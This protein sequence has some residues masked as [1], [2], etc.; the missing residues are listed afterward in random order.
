MKTLLRFEYRKWLY[1]GRVWIT[2]LTWCILSALATR[3][4][5]SAIRAINNFNDTSRQYQD[6]RIVNY[7]AQLDSA[8]KG[9][10]AFPKYDSDPRNPVVF[11]RV[12]PRFAFFQ[13]GP[14]NSFATGQSDVF[15][16]QYV[17][18]YRTDYN[19][20]KEHASNGLAVLYGRFDISFLVTF[21]LP[22]FIIALNYN[23]LSAEKENGTLKIL[24]SQGATHLQLACSKTIVSTSFFTLL[25]LVPV[26][27][28]MIMTK[29][30]SGSLN[31]IAAYLAIGFL[32]TLF[33]HILSVFV[34]RMLKSSAYN[35]TLLLSWWLALVIVLPSLVNTLTEIVHPVPSRTKFITEYRRVQS[36][37][38]RDSNSAVLDKYFF[39][40]P[41]LVKQDTAGNQRNKAN[42]FYKASHVTQDKTQKAL[43]PVYAKHDEALRSA[44]AFA[45]R[46]GRISPAVCMQQSLTLLAGQSSMQYQHFNEKIIQWRKQY[47]P[48]ILQKLLQDKEVTTS[49]VERFRPFAYESYDYSQKL[50]INGIVLLL[51]N[52]I[53]AL[54]ITATLNRKQIA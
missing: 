40:H 50:L 33:W 51:I 9:F 32:Y 20:Q 10:K 21:L 18:S 49:E 26:V 14:L 3:Q 6:I 5:V 48:F 34:N 45:T 37:I 1:S 53:L 29:D 31:A 41:E 2:L 24:H 11:N 12:S 13:P 4:R 27:C 42:E 43:E 19:T 47:L 7:H 35:A 30:F 15:R 25:L 44:N 23:V 28:S 39:D 46:I 16:F 17:I 54:A 52:C 22:L 36:D 8:E 38:G